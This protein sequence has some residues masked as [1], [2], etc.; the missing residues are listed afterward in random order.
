MSPSSAD[1]SGPVVLPEVVSRL[2]RGFKSIIIDSTPPSQTSARLCSAGSCRR[3]G[4]AAG[5][6]DPEPRAQ[7]QSRLLPSRE[8]VCV[9]QAPADRVG[10]GESSRQQLL[11]HS[12][13]LIRGRSSTHLCHPA[14]SPI[15]S[16]RSSQI[17]SQARKLD[18]N[19]AESQWGGF[20]MCGHVQSG[21][22]SSTHRGAG[23]APSGGEQLPASSMT[24][25]M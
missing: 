12:R 19:S 21:C 1:V 9:D 7:N 2:I 3:A 25:H 15:S 6:P 18:S 8:E 24:P 11:S 14:P 22:S 20:I 17:G 23:K 4:V 13:R 10:P 16:P 5:G